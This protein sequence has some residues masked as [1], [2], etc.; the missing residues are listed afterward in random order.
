MSESPLPQMHRHR[1]SNLLE[2]ADLGPESA[3]QLPAADT[4]DLKPY[5]DCLLGHYR[6]LALLTLAALLS[7]AAISKLWMTKWYMAHAQIKP[8]S[9][10]L[11]NGMASMGAG[12]LKG[13]AGGLLGQLALGGSGNMYDQQTLSAMLSSYDLTLA[14]IRVYNLGPQLERRY[15]RGKPMTP[16]RLYQL[17]NSHLSVKYSFT[18]ELLNLT[19]AD[20]DPMLAGQILTDYIDLLRE[21][22][23]NEEMRQA[24]G[25]VS[26]LKEELRHTS[27]SLLM[28]QLYEF[29][30][31]QI[32]RERLA[33]VQADFAFIV[34]EPPV[35]PD[36]AY[37]PKTMVNCLVAALLTFLGVG[38]A[39]IYFD[40][41]L[42]PP[43]PSVGGVEELTGG[44]NRRGEL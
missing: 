34:I 19:F 4:F 18:D 7:S 1:V 6:L 15:A 16:W 14:L 40:T 44:L 36:Q 39:V 10:N 2:G 21:R 26:S 30:A 27:D 24:Q 35:V 8:I 33:E 42:R 43:A 20:P 31:E 38:S 28:A 23:R 17:L 32:Q 22:L 13:A 25:A 5:L 9:Q 3:Y 29:I 37:W 11:S 41:H 12:L